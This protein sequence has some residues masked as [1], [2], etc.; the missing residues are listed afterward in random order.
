MPKEEVLLEFTVANPHLQVHVPQ[1]A[2][3]DSITHEVS[4]ETPSQDVQQYQRNDSSLSSDSS[5]NLSKARWKLQ[6]QAA[7]RSLR[8]KEIAKEVSDL[9]RQKEALKES[10]R[11]E[12]HSLFA[13]IEDVNDKLTVCTMKK[14]D[15]VI[16][17]VSDLRLEARNS[18]ADYRLHPILTSIRNNLDSIKSRQRQVGEKLGVDVEAYGAP[19]SDEGLQDFDESERK[20]VRDFTSRI[21]CQSVEKIEELFR[22]KKRVMAYTK[23]LVRTL[24]DKTETLFNHT[25]VPVVSAELLSVA[26]FP[27]NRQVF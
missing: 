20:L 5:S 25:V 16:D 8:I 6:E 11:A 10:L 18:R 17:A 26:A 9:L 4:T 13:D 23:A 22:S 1:A 24:P 14:L 12:E 2:K 7:S 21:P 19:E 27:K 3:E 15:I